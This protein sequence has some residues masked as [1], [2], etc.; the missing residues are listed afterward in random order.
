MSTETMD[1]RAAYMRRYREEHREHIRELIR[2]R[3]RRLYGGKPR[4]PAYKTDGLTAQQRWRLRH[5]DEINA[6]KREE[7]AAKAKARAKAKADMLLADP[8]AVP[9]PQTGK[10]A[11]VRHRGRVCTDCVHYLQ[12]YLCSE[13]FFEVVSCGIRIA[14]TCVNYD[15][16]CRKKITAAKKEEPQQPQNQTIMN[17]TK[18][19][20]EETAAPDAVLEA[21]PEE[22]TAKKTDKEY[23]AEYYAKNREQVLARQRERYHADIEASRARKRADKVRAALASVGADNVPQDAPARAENGH[24][25]AQQVADSLRFA[26]ETMRACGVSPVLRLSEAGME[27]TVQLPQP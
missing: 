23:Y 20:K 14:E 15:G 6:R 5:K 26:L 2:D 12:S 17:K 13:S 11:P 9:A 18:D 10:N 16:K 27:I 22:V 4:D 8:D 7:R 3:Y 1:K 19:Q 24:L 25:L 21:V